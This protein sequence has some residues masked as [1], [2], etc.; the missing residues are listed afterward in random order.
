ML[1]DKVIGITIADTVKS[2]LFI[3]LSSHS[4]FPRVL[5]KMMVFST[6]TVS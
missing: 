1:K 3:S 5:Q 4:T 2:R 6:F